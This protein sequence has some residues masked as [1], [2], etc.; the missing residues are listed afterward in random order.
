MCVCV[1]ENVSFIIPMNPYCGNVN[2]QHDF[3]VPAGGANANRKNAL[4]GVEFS[5]SP[6]GGRSSHKCLELFSTYRVSRTVLRTFSL[7]DSCA[8]S[9]RALQCRRSLTFYLSPWRRW[10]ELHGGFMAFKDHVTLFQRHLISLK[11]P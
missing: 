2:T 1:F 7:I 11:F 10:R 4:E 6:P 3:S 5:G 9:W 8:V